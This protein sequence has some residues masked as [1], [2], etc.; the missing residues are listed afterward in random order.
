[1]STPGPAGA[2]GSTGLDAVRA[3]PDLQAGGSVY[4]LLTDGSTAEIRPARP[5]DAG[6][7]RA[8]HEALSPE[9]LYLRFFTLSRGSAEQEAQRV[10]R[11]A[12]PDHAVLLAWLG[13]R[14][15]GVASYEPGGTAGTAEVAFAVP[16]DMHRR[17]VAT[18]LLE[19]LVSL[20]RRRGLAAFTATTLM[21]NSAM[22]HVFADAGLP[23]RRRLD[24]GV[25]EWTFPLPGGRADPALESYLEAV[26]GR[27][28]RADVASLRYL[29][30]PRSIAVIGASRRPGTVGRAVLHNIVAG[31]FTGTIYAVDSGAQHLEG[32]PCVASV[33]D[34]PEAAD[35]AVIAVP[36]AAV[37]EV[38]AACGRRGVRALAVL[39]AGLGAGAADLLAAC[40]R[41]GMRLAGP[42]SLGVIV[43]GAGLNASFAARQPASG[44]AGVVVQSGAVGIA[45]LE[46]LSRLGIGVSSFASVGDKYDVSSNDLLMWWGQDGLTRL[47]IL[48]VESFGSPRGFAR[49]ARRV[50][51][52]MPV[53]TVI[54]GRSAASPGAASLVTQEALFGQAGVIAA[55]GLGELIEAAALLASQPLPAGGRVAIVS[56]AGGA[57]VLAADACGD[58][59]LT[60]AKL[61]AATR[62]RL[63][64]LLPDGAAVAGPVD[65]TA[66]VTAGAFR[67]CLEQVAAD[68]GV[69]AVIAVTVPTAMADLR[70]AIT[71]AAVAKPLLAVLLEQAE[72]VR[73]LPDAVPVP[74]SPPRP[75]GRGDDAGHAA[76]R[77]LA[78]QDPGRPPA[79]PAL[80]GIPAYAY[81]EAAARA[82]GHAVRYRAWRDRQDVPVPELI[83]LRA[84]AARELVAGFLAENAGGG[85]LSA[86]QAAEL[87]S[88]YLIQVALP[89]GAPAHER[90]APA[91]GAAA[92]AEV[93]IGVVQEPVFGPLIVFGL[94]G[95]A[96]SIPGGY[97]A[98]L[99]PLSP[100]DADDMIR[101]LPGAPL[102][103]GQG[104]RPADSGALADILVRVSRLADDLPEVAELDLS[105]VIT[106]S[107]G[108]CATG[109]RVRVTAA[110]H[111][112]PFLRRL[113]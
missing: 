110:E 59:G 11:P 100:S 63:R 77:E 62:R 26:A 39:T 18:L 32:V 51:Q 50:G 19:H 41:H 90:P 36:A 86:S 99:T 105:P 65:T 45:L 6:A 112:D 35:L 79:A 49:T 13:G 53:L 76:R 42:N 61:G 58:S 40:R 48:Y 4:A 91:A 52:H 8:M 72:S 64:G 38:A 22:L 15:I 23:A 87:L 95:V 78:A 83:G 92:G 66:A 25:V 107:D 12:G 46:Q 71:S 2:R 89:V 24:Y 108:V 68:D 69:D 34:L 5:G 82:L 113:R 30:A 106:R 21:D 93:A 98:R 1:V 43:P 85:W 97:A 14:L 31:G 33:A 47:A 57:G 54:G 75:G 104:A 103:F 55:R 70:P 60:V 111:T 80:D 94:G 84:A 74:V 27:E 73:L 16:D 17:G 37:P 28:S 67:A 20:A 10:C 7:V 29:L 88:C 96:V 102:L 81:P 9:N 56:S 3:A 101:S 109:A 44:A